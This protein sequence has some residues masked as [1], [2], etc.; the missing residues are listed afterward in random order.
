MEINNKNLY[1]I[2][3]L[4]ITIVTM[5]IILMKTSFFLN[6]DVSDVLLEGTIYDKITNK[7]LEKVDLNIENWIYEGGDYDAYGNCEKFNLVTNET[8]YFMLK[9]KKSA[10]IVIYLSK[11]D[12]SNDT[13]EIYPKVK[14]NLN[15]SIKSLLCRSVLISK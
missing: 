1:R 4:I 9:L 14:N 6:K 10:Y 2:I 13:I 8:G 5:W 7:E 11:N 12:Y 3:Y 15:I